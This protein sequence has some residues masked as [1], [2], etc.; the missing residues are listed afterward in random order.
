MKVYG[1]YGGEASSILSLFSQWH[2]MWSSSS[3]HI[4]CQGK[5]FQNLVPS[6]MHVPQNSTGHNGVVA[7]LLFSGN[8]ALFMN[9]VLSHF[10]NWAI[11]T[12][13]CMSSKWTVWYI[14]TTEWWDWI[15]SRNKRLVS[16]QNLQDQLHAVVFS[17]AQWYLCL[18]LTFSTCPFYSSV[19]CS[20]FP[21]VFQP[22]S[23]KM[24][25]NNQ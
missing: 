9:L 16:S 24:N 7:N 21:L 15:P 25:N 18:Y 1:V 13:N 12:K 22:F 3:G 19:M 14:C 10:T 23:L 6:R 11:E 20:S 17:Y 4:Y 8:P 2:W 5:L